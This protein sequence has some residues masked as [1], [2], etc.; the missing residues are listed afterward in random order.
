VLR[1]EYR[2]IL[3]GS[4]GRLGDR[5]SPFVKFRG[6]NG[7]LSGSPPGGR[8]S[9]SLSSGCCPLFASD[10]APLG[11]LLPLFK[12]GPVT[13]DAQLSW[14]GIG[15]PGGTRGRGGGAFPLGCGALEN[16]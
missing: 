2:Q 10:R 8:R 3:G 12:S 6:R 1:L 13:F 14:E 16:G 11:R 7:V 15:V 5:W 4:Y 9:A